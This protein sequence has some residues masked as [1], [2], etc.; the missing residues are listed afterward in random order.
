[1]QTSIPPIKWIVSSDSPAT[2][3]RAKDLALAGSALDHH[4]IDYVGDGFSSDGNRKWTERLHRIG[5]YF[6]RIEIVDESD[7]SFTVT[8]HVRDGAGRYWKDIAVRI[9]RTI[10]DAGVKVKR[11][12]AAA[13]SYGQA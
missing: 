7:Q 12:C 13:S 8:F 10:Q 5:D 2:L 9:L 6:D 1:M 11:R 3:C 4:A